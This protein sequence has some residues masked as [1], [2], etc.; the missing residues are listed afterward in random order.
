[1]TTTDVKL[2]TAVVGEPQPQSVNRPAQLS[3][4]EFEALLADVFANQVYA[5]TWTQYTP[6]FN[7]GDACV[8][9]VN[10]GEQALLKTVLTDEDGEDLE[11]VD[12]DKLESLHSYLSGCD[13][14][15][16]GWEEDDFLDCGWRVWHNATQG[17]ITLSPALLAI[18]ALIAAL[19]GG[20]CDDVLLENF[21]D[22]TT[23]IA[24]PNEY[25]V[26]AYDHD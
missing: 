8:F 10:L 3:G 13:D 25:I 6:Y 1:M 11:Y 7:D 15:P 2:T 16:E 19:E 22:H 9:G 17:A 18:K 4:P 26:R 23:V 5:V 21:G 24:T 12:T 14:L 20:H